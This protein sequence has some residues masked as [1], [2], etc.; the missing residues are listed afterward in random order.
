[1]AAHEVMAPH[2]RETVPSALPD[3][4]REIVRFR[5]EKKGDGRIEL[6]EIVFWNA[7]VIVN[8]AVFERHF[9]GWAS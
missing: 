2:C 9:V 7:G 8:R 6:G 3:V 4:V 1:M 5:F